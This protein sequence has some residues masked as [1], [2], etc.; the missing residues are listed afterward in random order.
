MSTTWPRVRLGDVLRKS[1]E[2]IVPE[3]GKEYREI[4][5][6]LWGKGVV[7]RGRADGAS[8]SGRRFVARQGQ[9]IASRIDARNGAIGL[10][11]PLLDGALVTNDFPLFNV[12]H[13]RLLPG[14]L[15]WFCRTGD[16]VELCLRA[17]EGTTN[18]VRLKEKRFLALEISLPPL[19][20]QRRIVARIEA[21]AAQVAEAHSIRL[22]ADEE[23]DALQPQ[24]FAA[25]Y[26]Y[27]A[28]IGGTKR[29]HEL[30]HTITDGT[31][32][33]P[34]YVEEGVPFLSVKD[35]TSG[36]ISF[37][38]TRFVSPV[39]H[40]ELTRRCKP[41]YGD[42]L[43]TKV[44]TT[45]FAKA[46]DVHREFSIFVSLALLTL[47]RTLLNP[48][49]TEFMLN[50]AR[51]REHSSRGTRGVGNKNLVLKFIREFPMPA[52]SLSEQHRIVEYLE[53][54]RAQVNALKRLQAETAAELEALVPAILDRAFRGEL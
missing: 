30:Y 48:R 19:V 29:L 43:L 24:V 2:T 11:P 45:G 14:L 35:I 54:V 25:V 8:L 47:D 12:E 16:F 5:V 40:A 36:H 42:V 18:R 31:H 9:F 50:S 38:N 26:D 41:E 51:L 1:E 13:Q 23:T 3:D 44:G 15:G 6:R 37:A 53:G 49:F 21:L 33:T 7:E 27:A 22:R 52:P 28:Q 32:L 10:V 46:I 34:R 17:S 39:E 4:T 20:E